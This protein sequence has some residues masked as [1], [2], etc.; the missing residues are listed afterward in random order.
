M[1]NEEYKLIFAENLKRLM[2]L[3]RV[4]TA[5]LVS[6]LNVSKQAV[7]SWLNGEKIPRMDKIEK[8]ALYFG[9]R[10]SDLLESRHAVSTEEEDELQVYLEELRTRPEMRLLFSVSKNATR[11][12][13]ERAVAIIEALKDAQNG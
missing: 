8:L 2:E 11:E 7:S 6:L 12:D 1:S 10:K 9:I 5:D 4:K 3:H 13:V